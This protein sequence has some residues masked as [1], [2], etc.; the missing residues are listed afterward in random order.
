MSECETFGMAIL[1]HG[2]ADGI[3]MVHDSN[4]HITEFVDPI[5]RNIT[6]L[7]KPKVNDLLGKFLRIFTHR[8]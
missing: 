3:L 5:K 6:L 2:E 7:S 4:M 1:T 8:N